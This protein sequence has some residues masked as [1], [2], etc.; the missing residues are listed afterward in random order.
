MLDVAGNTGRNIVTTWS[1]HGGGKKD[2]DVG[3]C[4]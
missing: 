4:R 3:C 1:Q 2:S